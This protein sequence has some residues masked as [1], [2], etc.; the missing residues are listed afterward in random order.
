MRLQRFEGIIVESSGE[1]LE[2]DDVVDVVDVVHEVL[3]L[4]CCGL[5][6]IVLQLHNE[7]A[8]NEPGTGYEAL[9]E[10]C[11]RCGRGCNCRSKCEESIE[12][13]GEG[14]CEMSE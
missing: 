2:R 3:N 11:K 14:D 13:H 8:R 5:T 12:I 6:G 10:S 4:V 7:L 9:V 1:A